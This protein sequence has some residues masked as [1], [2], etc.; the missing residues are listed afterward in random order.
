M[1][2]VLPQGEL[3]DE[4]HR[5]RC[6]IRQ[7]IVYRRQWGLQRFRDYVKAMPAWDGLKADF[8]EQWNKG[9]TGEDG[10]WF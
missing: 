2:E 5:R 10:K 6:W 3:D 7:L 8:A 4:T 1:S 9:N